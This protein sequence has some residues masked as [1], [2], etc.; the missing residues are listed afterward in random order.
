MYISFNCELN[1]ALFLSQEMEDKRK[2]SMQSVSKLARTAHL[3]RKMLFSELRS[4]SLNLI[5]PL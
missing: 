4:L 2:K 5:S 3:G 1:F